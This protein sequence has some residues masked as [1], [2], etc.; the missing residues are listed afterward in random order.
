[1]ATTHRRRRIALRAAGAAALVAVTGCSGGGAEAPVRPGATTSPSA[2]G[3]GAGEPAGPAPKPSSTATAARDDQYTFP[4]KALPSSKT[5]ALAFVRSVTI[6]ADGFGAGFRRAD[7]YEGDPTRWSVLGRDC[8]WRR[9]P[10]P[11]QVRASLTREFVKPGAGGKEAARVKVTVTVHESVTAADRDMAV[12]LETSMRCPEQWLSTTE[13]IR[14]LWSRGDS[15][16]GMRAAIS[17]DDLNETGEYTSGNGVW[18]GFSWYKYRLGPITLSVTARSGGGE[19][20]AEEAETTTGVASG[21]GLVGADID[22]RGAQRGKQLD[23][24]GAGDE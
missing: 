19:T 9:E 10:L 6:T 7:P 21:I 2:T 1:M 5:E 14:K 11:P 23:D 24:K 4:E 16:G 15:H 17:D 22:R 12:S 18:N 13:R 3:S 8:L 20:E